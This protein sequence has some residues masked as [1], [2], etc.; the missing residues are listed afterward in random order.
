[1]ATVILC[2]LLAAVLYGVGAAFE[3]HQAAGAPASS[4][5]R[6]RLIGLL[7]RQPAWLLG[8]AAQLGGFAAHAVALR[9]GPLTI[10]QMVVAAELIVSVAIVRV[11]SGQPL[12]RTAW[13][14]GAAVVAGIGAFL[15]LT[16]CGP[17]GD[18][19]PGHRLGAAGLGAAAAGA[20]AI[21]TAI[22]GLSAAGRRRA[23]LLAT[24]AGLADA[25]L[26]VATMALA[27][28]SGRGIAAIAG[29]WP[30]YAVVAGGLCSL[31]LTQT[32]YQAAR[33]MVTLPV[34]A[35]VTPAASVVI[36]IGFLGEIARLGTVRAIAAGLAAA[37]TAAALVILA[38]SAPAIDGSAGLADAGGL[39]A[40]HGRAGGRHAV[41]LT[42]GADAELGEHLPQV[43][44]DGV[45]ADE[46]P[47]ADLRVRQAVPGQPRDLGLLGGQL[48]AGPG[49]GRGGALAGGFPG[50]RQLPARPL[51][52]PVHPDLV[53]H[54]VRSAEL[55]ARLR[56]AALTA[57]PLAVQQVRGPGRG[58]ARSTWP[59]TA[60][61][62]LFG[63]AAHLMP[64][65]GQGANVAML[66]GALRG[67]ALAAHPG[68][69]PAA[70]Q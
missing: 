63:D 23:L 50:G 39:A 62:T 15:A 43:V 28:V 70:G 68:D 22:G 2:A 11:R 1:M 41:Q 14:A 34:I 3:Q 7:V 16:S 44:L 64:P 12:P 33:P 57:Q 35:S 65:V 59:S 25:G 40:G 36:G 69:V 6:P 46:Q 5:G 60:G 24:A 56:A 29:S 55:L 53:Q 8:I 61:A 51:G 37:G 32:A 30:V 45:R 58:G 21:A 13:A 26:A 49:V 48:L 19:G 10:V 20:A 47:G 4:A 9:S 38:R 66:D 42:A 17:A 18:P 54:A 67:L 52:E 31:L 27:R